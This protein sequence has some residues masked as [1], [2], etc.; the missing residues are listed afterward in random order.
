MDKHIL[1]R[2]LDIPNIGN[3]KVYVD[4]V[5][6]TIIVDYNETDPLTVTFVA[7]LAGGEDVII[8]EDDTTIIP[9]DHFIPIDEVTLVLA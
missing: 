1:L 4:G 9:F 2:D 7:P 5:L 8:F 3:L 6:Q